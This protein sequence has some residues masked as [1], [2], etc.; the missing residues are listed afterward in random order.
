[1]PF[2]LKHF[3]HLSGNLHTSCFSVFNQ[4]QKSDNTSSLVYADLELK[5]LRLK[6]QMDVK[7]TKVNEYIPCG[8]SVSVIRTFD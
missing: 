5:D 7:T 8:Y 2:S 6:E 4:H 3:F 1:M